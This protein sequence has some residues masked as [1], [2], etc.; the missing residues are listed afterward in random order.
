[1][2]LGLLNDYLSRRYRLKQPQG[3]RMWTKFRPRPALLCRFF[4]DWPK[5]HRLRGLATSICR[6]F[7][8]AVM[9]PSTSGVVGSNTRYVHRKKETGS[10]ATTQHLLQEEI[11]KVVALQA[12]YLLLVETI[13]NFHYTIEK[14]MSHIVSDLSPSNCSSVSRGMQRQHNMSKGGGMTMQQRQRDDDKCACRSY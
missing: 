12:Y 2:R 1:M 10:C 8:R 5:I 7:W 3:S 14:G 11:F 6:T 13:N 4:N 9:A